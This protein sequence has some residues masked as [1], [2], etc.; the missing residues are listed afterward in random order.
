MMNVA[1]MQMDMGQLEDA[2]KA[3]RQALALEERVLGPSQPET[4]L[5]TYNLT[6]ILARRGQTEESL[7]LLRQAIDHGLQPRVDLKIEKAPDLESLHG[8]PRFA[9]LVV[10][11]KE[12]AASQKAD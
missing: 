12:I 6:C 9:A 10:H 4:A 5:T 3:F 11:A 7:S 2:E 1:A 8:D